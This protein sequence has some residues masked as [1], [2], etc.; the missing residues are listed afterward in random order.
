MKSLKTVLVLSAASAA[1]VFA[2]GTPAMA[3]GHGDGI[4]G[5]DNIVVQDNDYFDCDGGD[6]GDGGNGGHALGLGDHDGGLLGGVISAVTGGDGGEGGNGGD[7]D[8]E[9]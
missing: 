5:D 9:N 8:C 1:A 6:G 4:Y 2:F 3:G 7:A